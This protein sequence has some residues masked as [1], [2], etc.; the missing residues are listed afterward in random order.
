MDLTH[1]QWRKSSRSSAQGQCVEV[2][3]NIPG[4]CGIRDSKEPGGQALVLDA[5]RFGDLIRSVK[6]DR[7][8]S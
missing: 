2:A 5:A 1:A 4:V 8:D 3:T 6:A 7:F